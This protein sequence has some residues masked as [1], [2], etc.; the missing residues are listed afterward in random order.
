MKFR[1]KNNCIKEVNRLQKQIGETRFDIVIFTRVR[2]WTHYPHY[3]NIHIMMTY[4]VRQTE[5]GIYDE[6]Y[7]VTNSGSGNETFSLFQFS[8]K[9]AFYSF[10][11]FQTFQTK[12]SRQNEFRRNK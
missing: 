10:Q 3:Q 7:E 12:R 9:W 11:T 4:K 2:T 1:N 8:K 5:V 6:N